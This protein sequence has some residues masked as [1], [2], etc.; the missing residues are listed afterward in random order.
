[1]WKKEVCVSKIPFGETNPKGQPRRALI[2]FRLPVINPHPESANPVNFLEGKSLI[3]LKKGQLCLC[4]LFLSKMAPYWQ[5]IRRL[6]FNTV[7]RKVKN[8]IL[9][10]ESFF[11]H[12]IVTT[13]YSCVKTEINMN[14]IWW[15]ECECLKKC[16]RL[17]ETNFVSFRRFGGESHPPI[18][19]QFPVCYRFM[20]C[21]H[22]QHHHHDLAVY[23]FLIHALVEKMQD[24]SISHLSKSQQTH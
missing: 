11:F 14:Y 10:L 6:K 13:V 23:F 7:S 12:L 17:Q 3:S 5:P 18:L 21:W 19:S 4:W 22:Y 1:M 16:I 9:Y 24:L 20:L 15:N 2:G 8:T